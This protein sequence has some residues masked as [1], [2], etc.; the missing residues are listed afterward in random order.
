MGVCNGCNIRRTCGPTLVVLAMIAGR[1][2]RWVVAAASLGLIVAG[3]GDSG[4]SPAQN[5]PASAEAVMNSQP[6]ESAQWLFHIEPLDD[7]TAVVSRNA[8]AITPMG[9]N[10]KLYSVGT[11]LEAQ[12]PETTITTPVHQVQD[13]LVL[14]AQGDLVMGGRQA[15]SGKLGYSI[16]PQPDAN[17]LPGAKPAPGDPLAGLDDLARQVA[18]SGVKSVA[19][20]QID[21]RL[22]REW[23]AHDEVI[24][25]IVI[26]D[27]LLAIQS[28]PTAPGQQ[29]RLKIVPETAA[30]VVVNR[31]VTV[32]AGEATSVEISAA[33]DS[34][35]LVV[36][37]QIAA[38]SDPLLNVF[39][40][41]DPA[42]FARTLFI[43]ALQRQDV[44]VEANPRAP[45]RTRELPADY[46]AGSEIAAITSP[47]LTQIATL[48]WKISH[49]YGANLATCLV[50]VQSGSKDCE[51]GLALIHERI[52]DVGIAAE[53]VWLIDG[54]GE[55]FSS[56]TPQA[57]VTW[58]KWLRKRSWGD[59]LSEM[60]PI[61]GVDGSLMMFQTDS[62]ATGQVQAKTGTYAGGEPGTNRLL[63]PAQV[64]AGLMTGAD[65]QQYAFSLYAAGG[66]Y[67]NIS[68][69]IFDSAR[70]VADVA[71][72]FQQDL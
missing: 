45:N 43:E 39:H 35:K 4:D 10:T 71:A 44:R 33:P 21:D 17:G 59:Q 20:V 11:W 41:P 12:G 64:L 51:S 24:S 29:A 72:A 70:N 48:I 27:N 25:P 63:M 47:E 23:E 28:I 69:G 67:E 18:R 16:P 49:N 31:V 14:V 58:V 42:S 19:D 13:T 50:A 1:R 22:F 6:Y 61:L 62:A 34:R 36:R 9:S 46:P 66:S 40:V 5:V 30:F 37:G 65:G 26:N 60:L 55:S 32:A 54:A 8:S 3:C 2:S 38:D 56:T 52:E 15:S 57:M 53:S 7:D 68:D